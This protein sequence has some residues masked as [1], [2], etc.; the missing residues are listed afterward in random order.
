MKRFVQKDFWQLNFVEPTLG[1][2]ANSR[3]TIF[4]KMLDRLHR[5]FGKEARPTPV[6]NIA[7][8]GTDCTIITTDEGIFVNATEG[9]SQYWFT[10]TTT[11]A[12]VVAQ[13]NTYGI[14]TAT[15]QSTQ[16]AGLLAK[17][18]LPDAVSAVDGN[19]ELAYPTSRLW[20]EL[21]TLAFE[22]ETQAERIQSAKAQMYFHTTDTD[23][24][25]IWAKQYFGIERYN[26]ESDETYRTRAIKELLLPTQNNKA[27]EN[28]VFE[29]FGVNASIRDA[30]PYASELPPPFTV[31]DAHNRFLLDMTIPID[32]PVAEADALIQKIKNLV[33]KYKSAGTDFVE[34]PLRK[35]QA[36]AENISTTETYHVTIDIPNI[37]ETLLDGPI[38][39]G[40]GWRVG[41]PGLTVG[42]NSAVKEQAFISVILAADD[43][44]VE[45]YLVGG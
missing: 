12:D 36:P 43:T 10:S 34:V 41:T 5:V 14:L 29:A 15:L 39:V 35:L 13:L 6:I 31:N 21:K 3:I 28:I 44:T 17:G 27:L 33:R 2:I 8:G 22:L 1:Y 45:Q 7:Y 18:I 20:A 16:Y 25:D 19:I 24:L 23:W 32:M 42:M 37:S 40:A 38:R 11:L 30:V 26:G 9:T 4:Q